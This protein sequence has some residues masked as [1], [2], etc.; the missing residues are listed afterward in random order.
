[1][2][3]GRP[4]ELEWEQLSGHRD[5]VIEFKRLLR[6]E[7]GGPADF[8]F[9]LT[10]FRGPY[11]TPRHRHNY[12]QIRI[13][14]DE[15]IS[16]MPGRAVLPG[17]IGYFPEGT[18]YGPQEVTNDPVTAALQFG[19]ASGE[20]FVGYDALHRGF[21]ELAGEGVFAGGVYR[22]TTPDGRHVNTDGYQAVWEHLTGRPMRYARPA[23]AEPVLLFPDAF[24]AHP[25]EGEPGVSVAPLGEFTGAR[26]RLDL[27][28]LDAG[29]TH[30]DADPSRGRILF[31][32]DGALDLAADGGGAALERWAA[33][34]LAAGE[35]TEVTARGAARVVAIGLPLLVPGA[36]PPVFAPAD[37]APADDVPSVPD[38]EE[39]PA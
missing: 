22:R 33:V 5:G 39:I 3:V 29:A 7:D 15:P 32:L 23:Y 30:L 16:Y 19:G 4:S 24:R 12:D 27:L 38:R 10:R 21:T 25:V 6:R 34:H 26:T 8:E 1:M 13:G 9:A 31:V 2:Q 14:L 36:A 35:A 18:P 17:S 11:R 28:R 20:G 37:D